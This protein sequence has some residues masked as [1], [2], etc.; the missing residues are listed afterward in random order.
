MCKFFKKRK[1]LRI[2]SCAYYKNAKSVKRQKKEQAN[3]ACSFSQI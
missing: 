3:H 1:N 2:F